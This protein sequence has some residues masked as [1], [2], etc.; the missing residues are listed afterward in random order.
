MAENNF[1]KQMANRE[2]CDLIF[3]EYSTK[4]NR[5]CSVTMLIH[6]V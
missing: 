1:S 3:E 6:Q 5:S 2:V 4:K